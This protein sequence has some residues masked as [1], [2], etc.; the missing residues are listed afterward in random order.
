MPPP[1]PP[2]PARPQTRPAPAARR[3]R[4]VAGNRGDA[5]HH[6][7]RPLPARADQPSA[8]PFRARA[9]LRANSFP[10]SR[11]HAGTPFL[12]RDP[13]ALSRRAPSTTGRRE[14]QK[15]T[16]KKRRRVLAEAPR[17]RR[18]AH[19]TTRDLAPRRRDDRPAA[20]PP[21]PGEDPKRAPTTVRRNATA[22]CLFPGAPAE[23][24]VSTFE[25]LGFNL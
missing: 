1:P 12:W 19:E 18:R 13:R 6:T 4:A 22:T 3:A 24:S 25:D 9:P 14:E 15:R 16:G 17:A 11:A 10:A 7:A 23:V 5:L 21:I 2:P 20:R 8:P